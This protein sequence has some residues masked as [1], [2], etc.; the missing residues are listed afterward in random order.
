MVFAL[1]TLVDASDADARQ[2]AHV[3]LV[4]LPSQAEFVLQPRALQEQVRFLVKVRFAR[5]SLAVNFGGRVFEG[6]LRPLHLERVGVI[7]RV[8]LQVPSL[9]H[10][11]LLHRHQRHKRL[12]LAQQL[13]RETLF[14]V[15]DLPMLQV[16]FYALFNL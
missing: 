1:N 7:S 3:G 4:L 9:G 8:Q 14:L 16:V 13:G 6:G 12:P 5:R 15:C 10:R 11:R 2:I